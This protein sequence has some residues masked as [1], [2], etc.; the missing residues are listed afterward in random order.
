MERFAEADPRARKDA[1]AETDRPGAASRASA[2]HRCR[3][4]FQRGLGATSGFWNGGGEPGGTYRHWIAASERK[5]GA[6]AAGDGAEFVDGDEGGSVGGADHRAAG[7]VGSSDSAG[8]QRYQ[9]FSDRGAPSAATGT[10][11]AVANPVSS[12]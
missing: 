4:E 12:G 10:Q 2:I 11:R 8:G 3:D 5:R 6:C 1:Q 9:R 7:G